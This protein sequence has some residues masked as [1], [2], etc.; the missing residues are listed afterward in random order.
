MSNLALNP[1]ATLQR[2]YAAGT[3]FGNMRQ[4]LQ[5]QADNPDFNPDATVIAVSI[6]DGQSIYCLNAIAG[7]ILE[8]TMLHK[9]EAWIRDALLE[10]FEVDPSEL[11]ADIRETLA[12]LE[13]LGIL[14]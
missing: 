7:F 6:P 11:E 10:L 13:S 1:Q 5:A 8:A 2:S 4:Y 12:N 3:S 9:D 14:Q